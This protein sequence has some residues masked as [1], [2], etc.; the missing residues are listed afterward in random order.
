MKEPMQ[1]FCA[2]DEESRLSKPWNG[3]MLSIAKLNKE[4]KRMKIWTEQKRTLWQQMEAD[5]MA[6]RR[7]TV[8]PLAGELKARRRRT[9]RPLGR[10]LFFLCLA[11]AALAVLGVAL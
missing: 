6:R 11:I 3:L 7:R 10:V 1:V 5:V 9:L 8:S 2:R 4:G